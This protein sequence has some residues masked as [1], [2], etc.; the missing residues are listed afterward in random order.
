MRGGEG[1]IA[2]I[3]LLLH[4]GLWSVEEFMDVSESEFRSFG[5]FF[6]H[7]CGA[8]EFPEHLADHARGTEWA[9]GVRTFGEGLGFPLHI[10]PMPSKVARG[11][12]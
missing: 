11:D 8:L 12:S 1:E 4:F 7:K 10:P 3:I 2:N 9:D 5:I 6:S